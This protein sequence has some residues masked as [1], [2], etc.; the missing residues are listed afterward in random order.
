MGTNGEPWTV[1]AMASGMAIAGLA[2]LADPASFR[3]ESSLA[4][5]R[6]PLVPAAGV[7]GDDEPAAGARRQQAIGS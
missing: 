7:P 2:G 5:W 4:K 1:M 6:G 3:P